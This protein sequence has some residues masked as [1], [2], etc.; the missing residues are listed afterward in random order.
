LVEPELVDGEFVPDEERDL[1]EFDGEGVD[2]HP[3]ELAQRD[4]AELLLGLLDGLLRARHLTSAF[5]QPGLDAPEFAVGEVEEVAAAAGG[6]E[7][8]VLEEAVSKSL[9]LGEGGRVLDDLE[10]WVDDRRLDDL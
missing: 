5:E 4:V 9:D 6:V 10:P 1:R 2:V 8:P 3:V 7:H